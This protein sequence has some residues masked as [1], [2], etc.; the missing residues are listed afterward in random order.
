[1]HKKNEGYESLMEL[2]KVENTVHYATLRK[3]FGHLKEVTDN[4]GVNS[5]TVT[6]ISSI[7]GPS[8][9]TV[10]SVSFL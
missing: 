2:M 7:F 10:D 4:C 9:F 8:L 1:M 3:L 5:M 6:N